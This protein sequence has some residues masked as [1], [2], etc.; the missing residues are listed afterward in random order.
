M[1]DTKVCQHGSP[2]EAEALKRGYEPFAM[3]TIPMPTQQILAGGARG[4]N[5]LFF[6]SYR[7]EYFDYLDPNGQRIHPIW[8]GLAPEVPVDGS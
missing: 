4:M 6:M 2:V 8:D 7:K 1:W 3:V 5:I